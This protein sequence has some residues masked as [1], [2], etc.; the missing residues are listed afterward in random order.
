[1]KRRPGFPE[2][3][4]VYRKRWGF[5][6]AEA[7]DALGYSKETIKAWECGR[8]YPKSNEI[9]RLAQ[10]LEV[11]SQI[12]TRAINESRLADYRGK[13]YEQN[14]AQ[15][16]NVSSLC[17]VESKQPNRKQDGDSV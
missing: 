11:D 14:P 12:L 4:K 6:Q 13:M 10:I 15:Q 17:Y 7:A 9:A 3:L 1:M 5:T 8:R 16:I 2:T